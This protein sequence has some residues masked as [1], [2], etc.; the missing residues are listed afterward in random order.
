MCFSFGTARNLRTLLPLPASGLQGP[1]V[2]S[3]SFLNIYIL[4]KYSWLTMFQVYSKVIQ[5]YMYTYII[6]QIIFC[7]RL[8]Q[9]IDYSSLHCIVNLCCLVHIYK[10]HLLK[11]VLMVLM[12]KWFLSGFQYIH[13]D[14]QPSS[15]SIL[16]HILGIP[17]ES[18]GKEL[19]L[20]LLGPGFKPW[21]G[22]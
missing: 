13:R 3:I 16:K 17:W 6:F 15:H 7:Y 21:S 19:V 2:L 9:N 18:S 22:N 20:S 12:I 4:L 11:W 1:C 5:L 8:L 10:I 14:I